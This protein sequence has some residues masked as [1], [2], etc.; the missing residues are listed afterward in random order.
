[1]KTFS[2]LTLIIFL[3]GC[4]MSKSLEREVHVRLDENIPVSIINN[5][6]SNFTGAGDET[7]YRTKFIEGMKAEFTTSKII[8]DGVNPEFEIKVSEFKITESTR[9][10]TVDDTSSSD[11]GKTFELTKLELYAQGTV[12][13][14]SDNVV[15]NWTASK[16]EEEKVTSLRSGGQIVT[17]QNKDKNEY[18]EKE[19]NDNEAV[20]LAWNC[21]RRSG[22]SAVKE[23]TRALK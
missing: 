17:G 10:E 3:T 22:N 2:L 13:R 5:G 9:E 7:A 14:L 6:N 15:Y 12:T 4:Y 8:P 18:R 20:D 19:L 23:I 16:N 11:H 21:G 1:M